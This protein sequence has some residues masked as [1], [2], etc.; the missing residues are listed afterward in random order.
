M[1]RAVEQP[2]EPVVIAQGSPAPLN[3]L[4]AMLARNGIAAGLMRPPP[5]SGSG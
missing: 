5:G 2:S 3:E 1:V 4:V